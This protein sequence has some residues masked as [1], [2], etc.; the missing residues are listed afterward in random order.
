VHTA[1]ICYHDLLSRAGR[2]PRNQPGEILGHEVSGEI[3]K[4]GPGVPD[5]RTGERVVVYQRLYCD[6]CRYC[7]AGRHDLC[8][9]S[10]VLGENGGGGY[11]EFTC[12][13]ARNLIKVP[14]SVDL[15]SA[16]LAACPIGTSIRALVG[17]AQVKAGDVVLV[18][19]AGGGLGLHQIQIAKAFNA[20][21]IAVTSSEEKAAAV[22]SA[23]ADEVII[24]SDLHF[25]QDV[26]R[27]T[28]KTGADIVLENV[29]AGTI[30]ESLRACAQHA[31][32]VI[33]GNI[34]TR[35]VEIDPGLVIARRLRIFGSGNATYADVRMALLLIETGKVKPVI[36][37]VLRFPDVGRGHHLM[38]QR[39][40]IGRAVLHGW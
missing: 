37:T 20:H 12:V 3:V 24:A 14:D 13:P 36:N 4:V 21:V 31:A 19:G 25:S 27:L 39:D 30:G 33:L 40:T 23:G 2:I 34:G 7:L 38:E 32:I 28:S 15:Q 9:N 17:V 10:R 11:A 8:R 16:A 6:E 22:R 26:W 1:G 5:H 18:T 29:V 35:P